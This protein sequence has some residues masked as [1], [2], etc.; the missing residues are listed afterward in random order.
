MGEV[1]NKQLRFARQ[2]AHGAFDPLWR[3]QG[4]G[5][6]NQMYQWLAERMDMMMSDCHIAKMDFLQCRQVVN[7]CMERLLNGTK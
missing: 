3:G 2:E 1:A 5:K 6:R 7:I 4:N